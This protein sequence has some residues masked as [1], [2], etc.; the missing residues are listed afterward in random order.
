MLPSGAGCSGSP[1][2][3]GPLPSEL[4]WIPRNP[5]PPSPVSSFFLLSGLLLLYLGGEA[6]VRGA[7]SLALRSG[8][9]ILF[10]GLTVV[11]F[12]TSSPELA[13]SLG[14]ALSGSSDVSLGNVVGSN[15]CNVGLILGLS[16]LIRPMAVQTQLLRVDLPLMLVTSLG[17]TALL[18]DGSLS[19]LDGVLLL[20]TLVAWL[21]L[22][23]WLARR[24]RAEEIELV[25]AVHESSLPRDLGYLLVGLAALAG[26]S[27]LFVRGAVAL[28]AS[29]G[30][31]EAVVALTIVALGTS[32]PEL[33]TSVVGAL[34]GEADVAIGNVV[35]SNLF[36]LLA[37]AGIT[38]VVHPISRGAIDRLDLGTMIV[39][40]ALVVPLALT[41]LRLT[42]LEGAALLVVYG[43]YL[44]LRLV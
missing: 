32:L 37:I 12:G 11:A 30:V 16:A 20:T 1:T 17:F 7:V 43:G 2:S 15:I 35:G 22:S 34:R 29:L 40:A 39:T 25:P 18:L 38:A 27:Q 41:G 3:L 23:L 6:L 19:R 14:A 10:V 21:G 5:F 31:P 26:G 4:P 24:S 28:A 13:V 8:L 9:S 33:A 36:N 42:R 44:V